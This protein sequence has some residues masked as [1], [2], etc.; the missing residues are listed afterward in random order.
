MALNQY[1]AGATSVITVTLLC[2][3]DSATSI[4]IHQGRGGTDD[5]TFLSSESQSHVEIPRDAGGS[6]R[7]VKLD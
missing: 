2:K 4:H 3:L 1:V 7:W 5:N 6:G